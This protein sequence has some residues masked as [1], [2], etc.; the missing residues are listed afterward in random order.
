MQGS[1]EGGVAS[2][3]NFSTGQVGTVYLPGYT[4]LVNSWYGLPDIIYALPIKMRFMNKGKYSSVEFL[5]N[6]P[7]PKWMNNMNNPY[8]GGGVYYYDNGSLGWT[9]NYG[10]W[11]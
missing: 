2:G 8:P 6:A 10:T 9:D 3:F 11:P 4:Y 1:F 5:Y 7:Q